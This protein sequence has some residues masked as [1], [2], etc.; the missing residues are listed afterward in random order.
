MDA[1]QNLKGKAV[2]IIYRGITY[3]GK[4]IGASG[5]E[6]YLQTSSNQIVL[7]MSGV[8]SVREMSKRKG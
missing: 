5:T 2:E 4:L 6:V 3:K 1:L 8:T 7:P